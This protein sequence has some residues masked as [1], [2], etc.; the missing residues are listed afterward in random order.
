MGEAARLGT[1]L[2]LFYTW[3]RGDALPALPELP[4]LTIEP[5]DGAQM[6][7][8]LDG[9]DIQSVQTR[10]EQQHHPY[11]AR[12]DGE[13]VG[14]GWVATAVTEIGELG[15]TLTM[16]PDNRYLWDFVTLP[17]WRG[18]RI[19]P[20]ILQRMLTLE[21]ADRF[22]IGH[23]R[24]NVASARGIIAAGFHLTGE[25]FDFPTGF[26]FVPTGPLNRARIAAALLGAPLVDAGSR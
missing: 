9:L 8:A 15:I 5:V 14:S 16:P 4:G 2:G 6:A 25:L 13:A 18:Q 11:L 20:R 19:Y 22:W 10:I 3:W 7:A 17:A 21:E 26:G 1:P 24:P 23:D 12:V